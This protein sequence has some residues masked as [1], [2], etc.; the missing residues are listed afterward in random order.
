V[1]RR[2]LRP[3]EIELWRRVA[4][5]TEKLH[6]EK[7]D[8]APVARPKP[9]PVKHPKPHL[10]PFRVGEKAPQTRDGH[11]VL[12]GISERLA[13]SPLHMDK[14]AFTRMKR[15][16]LLPEDKIDLHGMTLDQAHPA[17]V[18]FILSAHAAQMRLVLVI[19]GKGKSSHDHGPIPQRKGVLKHQ[20]PQWLSMPPLSQAVLQVSEAHLKHGGTGAY[21]VYLRRRR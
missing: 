7:R 2:R 20:V 8:S 10:Q 19:T 21:Y 15:G 3:D 16:K 17:L 9:T 11:D 18:S 14:K 5:S 12:P 4:D 1:T 6:P 13:K